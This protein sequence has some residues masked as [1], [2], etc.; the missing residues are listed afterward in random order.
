MNDKIELLE[1]MQR[2]ELL[3]IKGHHERALQRLKDQQSNELESL[4][5]KHKNALTIT[6]NR[7]VNLKTVEP[8]TGKE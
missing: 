4:S 7:I 3:T 2:S 6:E 5:K 8:K 1:K